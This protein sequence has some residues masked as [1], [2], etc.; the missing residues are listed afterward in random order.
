MEAKTSWG[1]EA[2]SSG[3]SGDFTVDMNLAQSKDYVKAEQNCTD[4]Q[5]PS[6]FVPSPDEFQFVTTA[7][8]S[9]TGSGTGVC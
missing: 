6:N 8:M 7:P 1:Q 5:S 9:P 4:P 2:T 3:F